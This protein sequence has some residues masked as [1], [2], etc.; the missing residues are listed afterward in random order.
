MNLYELGCERGDVLHLAKDDTWECVVAGP[1]TVLSAGEKLPLEDLTRIALGFP[2]SAPA[3]W[4]WMR[5]GRRLTA[6]V[7]R[8]AT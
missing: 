3:A 2:L 6:R 7:E 5:N 1:D 4:Y 8:D